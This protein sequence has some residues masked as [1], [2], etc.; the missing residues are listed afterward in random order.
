M[1]E[2]LAFLEPVVGVGDCEAGAVDVFTRSDVD[3]AV[4]GVSDSIYRRA[5]VEMLAITARK[6]VRVGDVAHE[7]WLTETA[8][9]DV[10]HDF[11]VEEL[12]LFLEL[13]LLEDVESD[14][15]DAGAA[16]GCCGAREPAGS[17]GC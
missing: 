13:S 8:G 9:E 2:R 3:E 4:L 17:F 15:L 6:S 16:P 14:A 12:A 1:L 5:G 11:F 10:G 7:F